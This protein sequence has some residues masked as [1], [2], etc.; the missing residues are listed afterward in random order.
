[1]QPKQLDHGLYRRLDVQQR[2][3]RGFAREMLVDAQQCAY[4]G[5]VEEFHAAEID[6]DGLNPRLPELLAF[7]LEVA[8][9]IRVETRRFHHKVQRLVFQLPLKNVGHA[10]EHVLIGE[11]RTSKKITDEASARN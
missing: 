6:G 4:P 8:G 2:N 9:S 7:A 11:A 1:M 5:A 3:L 10:S